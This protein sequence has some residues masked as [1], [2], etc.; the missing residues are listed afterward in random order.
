MITQLDNGVGPRAG[1]RVKNGA[2]VNGEPGQVTSHSSNCRKGERGGRGGALSNSTWV[3]TVG[4]LR[5][6]AYPPSPPPTGAICG[7]G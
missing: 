4:A 3:T 2:R 6:G 1:K 5:R 7:L